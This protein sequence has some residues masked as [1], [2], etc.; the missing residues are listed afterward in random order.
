MLCLSVYI[1][2]LASNMQQ[3]WC[4]M[5]GWQPSTWGTCVIQHGCKHRC[6]HSQSA[7]RFGAW[8]SH[9][10]SSTCKVWWDMLYTH[11][12]CVYVL[13]TPYGHTTTPSRL[14]RCGACPHIPHASGRHQTQQGPARATCCHAA[15]QHTATYECAHI[16]Y[17][18]PPPSTA[19]PVQSKTHTEY[20]TT[21][22]TTHY[23]KYHSRGSCR[24]AACMAHTACGAVLCSGCS[25]AVMWGGGGG[26]GG[27]AS[28]AAWVRVLLLLLDV[29]PKRGVYV[30]CMY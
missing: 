24:G 17:K 23:T 1:R 7:R 29:V 10:S 26:D 15:I 2:S 8:H 9:S 4:I 12:C 5:M 18:A 13:T 16:H 27:D 21:H 25:D 11:T 20:H 3:Q 6:W 19:P 28:G 30:G 14:H 22:C